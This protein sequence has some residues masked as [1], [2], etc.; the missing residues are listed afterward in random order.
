MWGAPW[1]INNHNPLHTPEILF[2]A[3]ENAATRF[4]D[5]SA[6]HEGKNVLLQCNLLII[7]R[8][9]SCFQSTPQP[10]FLF[11]YPRQ[12]RGKQVLLCLVRLSLDSRK[13]L[14]LCSM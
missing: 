3:F 12:L 5:E 9:P 10:Q 1:Y 4:K 8:C 14:G 11:F 2:L 6:G 13:R 7:N